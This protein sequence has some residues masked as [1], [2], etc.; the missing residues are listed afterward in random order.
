MTS[1]SE[2]SDVLE[3]LVS[4]IKEILEDGQPTEK[5]IK[6]ITF[7]MQTVGAIKG[8]SG[9]SRKDLVILAIQK[10]VPDVEPMLPIIS[11]IIDVF[12]D[13]EKRKIVFNKLKSNCKGC[14]CF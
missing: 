6:C 3:S 9:A 12:I 2:A 5:L 4:G 11:N 10:S 1:K 8:M 14:G 13:T 7:C